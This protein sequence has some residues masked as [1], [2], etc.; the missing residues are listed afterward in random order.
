MLIIVPLAFNT[1]T[2]NYIKINSEPRLFL[3]SHAICVAQGFADYLEC[4]QWVAYEI[5]FRLQWGHISETFADKKTP[6]DPLSIV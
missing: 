4:S 3:T 1:L 2:P 6:K 5:P